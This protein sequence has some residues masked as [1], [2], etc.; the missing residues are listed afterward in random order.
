MPAAQCGAPAMPSN[1]LR[2]IFS[3]ERPGSASQSEVYVFQ[4][5]LKTL[6]QETHSFEEFAAKQR[7]G[8][9]H[10]RHCAPEG[11]LRAVSKSVPHAP[12]AR[13]AAHQVERAIDP[14]GT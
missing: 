5:R 10:H 9:G 2:N 14:L 4:I 7:G 3:M 12:R 6:L 8:P 1:R 11:E 13:R